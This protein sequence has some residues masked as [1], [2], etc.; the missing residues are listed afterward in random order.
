MFTHIQKKSA[1]MHWYVVGCPAAIGTGKRYQQKEYQ[2]DGFRSG[3]WR[4]HQYK[5][6][7]TGG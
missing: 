7:F 3:K 2:I 6:S 1:F 5:V 4:Q